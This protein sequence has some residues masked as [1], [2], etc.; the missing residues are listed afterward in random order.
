MVFFISGN[1]FGVTIL[2][3]ENAAAVFF[4]CKSPGLWLFVAI[5]SRG[6]IAVEERNAVFMR[7][8]FAQRTD[9]FVILIREMS[10]VVEKLSKPFS[11]A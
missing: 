6:E 4:A 5:K 11:A 3:A 8:G 2:F 7:C 9:Q 1:G 10:S